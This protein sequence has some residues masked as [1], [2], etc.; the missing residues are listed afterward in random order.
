MHFFK[1]NS[2][3]EGPLPYVYLDARAKK[4]SESEGEQESIV[5]NVRDLEKVDQNERLAAARRLFDERLKLAE[6][7]EKTRGADAEYYPNE[8]LNLS[9]EQLGLA[10]SLLEARNALAEEVEKQRQDEVSVDPEIP[11]FS[12][13][14]PEIENMPLLRSLNLKPDATTVDQSEIT[15][16]EMLEALGVTSGEED[17]LETPSTEEGAEAQVQAAA[18][19]AGVLEEQVEQAAK[20]PGM[21]GALAATI[22][23]AFKKVVEKLKEWFGNMRD[24]WGGEKKEEFKERDI[25]S[26]PEMLPDNTNFILPIPDVAFNSD[27]KHD[28]PLPAGKNMGKLIDHNGFDLNYSEGSPLRAPADGRVLAILGPSES[29]GGGNKIALEFK[30]NGVRKIVTYSHMKAKSPLKVNQKVEKGDLVGYSGNTG[31]SSGPHL[32]LEVRKGGEW[33]ESYKSATPEDP[34]HYCPDNIKAKVV[35]DRNAKREKGVTDGFW[36]DLEDSSSVA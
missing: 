5:N 29:G 4:L 34:Y 25:I 7:A 1:R 15:E 23:G 11:E 24:W 13:D 9:A 17:E 14:I 22:G 31:V 10:E 30:V 20:E 19:E 12:E 16:G 28:R 32:H 35:A 33:G 6:E 3:F 27:M 21:L 26:D 18:E 2:D 8:M 36:T